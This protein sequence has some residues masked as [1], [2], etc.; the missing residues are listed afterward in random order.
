LCGTVQFNRLAKHIYTGHPVY[1]IQAKGID[2]AEE[3]F[4]RIEDMGSFYLKW[5]EHS[6]PEGPYILV[7]YS[8][9]GL[10]ALEMAQR[11][12]RAGKQVALLALIDTY[13]HPRFLSKAQ[14]AQLLA[15]R[16]KGHLEE[17]WKLPLAN[18]LAYFT[19][20]LKNRLRISDSFSESF[21]D[22]S[23][24]SA[25]EA[26]LKRVR[27]AAYQA[28]GTYE[29]GFYPGKINFITAGEKTFF[30]TNPMAVW[31]HLAAE[32]QVDE[33]PGNHLSIVNKEFEPLAAVLTRYVRELDPVPEF[34]L[35]S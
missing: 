22:T 10:V 18:A 33:V 4:N 31:R 2:G 9:G 11:L 14:Q 24:S 25:T 5:L 15:R 27:N 8:F 3:P 35:R 30:P 19:R 23:E 7:G 21:S 34:A 13:P 17:M 29:P 26:A 20:G 12:Q 28:Y 32:L 1:G 16:L 6:H